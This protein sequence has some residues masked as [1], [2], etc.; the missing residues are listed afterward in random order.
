MLAK[1]N[2]QGVGATARPGSR[3]SATSSRGDLSARGTTG[4]TAGRLGVAASKAAEQVKTDRKS[5]GGITSGTSRM[6]GRASA[7]PGAGSSPKRT[8]PGT[9]TTTNPAGGSSR[10]RGTSA[11]KE[12]GLKFGAKREGSQNRT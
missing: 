8:T 5:L 2:E 9:A 6:T 7:R 3:M 11:T 4:R 10:V 1:K 12:D